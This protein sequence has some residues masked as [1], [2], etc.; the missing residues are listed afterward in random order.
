[1]LHRGSDA[2]GFFLPRLGALELDASE[3]DLGNTRNSAHL[4]RYHLQQREVPLRCSTIGCRQDTTE[5][6]DPAD[7]SELE[8]V[9]IHPVTGQDTLHSL[10]MHTL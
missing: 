2:V 7:G 10:V 6:N 1:M 5:P 9:G 3:I 8:L 4:G